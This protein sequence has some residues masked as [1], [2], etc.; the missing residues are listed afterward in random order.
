MS[1]KNFFNLV[2]NFLES[3]KNTL[4]SCRLRFCRI[5]EEN[6]RRLLS[7]NL[8][9]LEVIFCDVT[10]SQNAAIENTSIETL[11]FIDTNEFTNEVIGS[12][13]N[14]CKNLSEFVVFLDPKFDDPF[15]E[16]EFG[17]EWFDYRKMR[18]SSISLVGLHSLRYAGAAYLIELMRSFTDERHYYFCYHEWKKPIEQHPYSVIEFE[19]VPEGLYAN[20]DYEDEGS[21][22]YEGTEDEVLIDHLASGGKSL[23]DYSGF[24]ISLFG[25]GLFVAA[26]VF[27]MLQSMTL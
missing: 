21:L 11:T 4:R 13:V 6:C 18:P 1:D 2:M 8:V 26:L 12:F 7:L 23:L 14:C 5:S 10:F 16:S 19:E 27:T 15:S 9:H 3:Q 22:E 20:F 24:R 17:Y 25:V